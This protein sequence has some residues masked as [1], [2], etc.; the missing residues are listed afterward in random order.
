MNKFLL[1]HFMGNY[2]QCIQYGSLYNFDDLKIR[3][4]I[5]IYFWKTFYSLNYKH[6]MMFI[7][8]INQYYIFIKKINIQ[9]ILQ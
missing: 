3:K 8:L 9:F 2:H 1:F 4:I 6:R 7:H 5:C